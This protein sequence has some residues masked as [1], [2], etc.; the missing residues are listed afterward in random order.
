MSARFEL[1]HSDAE[2][3]WHARFVAGNNRKVWTTETYRERNG[4]LNAIACLAEG[5]ITPGVDGLLRVRLH[6]N[7]V[8]VIREIDERTP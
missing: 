5:M 4:A 1:V 8:V 3:P 6:S 7:R 2:Q